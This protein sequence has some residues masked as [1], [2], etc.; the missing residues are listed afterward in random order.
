M[1]DLAMTAAGSTSNPPVSPNDDIN[2]FAGIAE[3]ELLYY[4]SNDVDSLWAV[5]GSFVPPP[6]RPP[7]L[8]EEGISTDGLTTCDLCTWA[9]RNDRHLS[10]SLD[11]TLEAPGE[12]GWV[13]TLIIVSLISAA[14]GAVVMVTLLHCRRIKSAGGRGGCCGVGVDEANPQE[15]VTSGAGGVA[16]GGGVSVIPD[17][18]PLELDKLPPY[19]D[20]TPT[21]GH[22]VWS[23]LGSRRGGGTAGVVTTPLSL[24]QHRCAINLPVENHYT[25]M[26]T[27]EALYAELDSQTASYASDLQLQLRGSSTYGDGVTTPGDEDEYHELDASRLHR[28]YSTSDNETLKRDSIRTRHSQRLK[29]PDYEMYENGPSTPI[30][31]H[32]QNHH[33]THP[34]P[35]HHHHHHH[36][37]VQSQR[38]NG[39]AGDV[40]PSYQNTGYTG[41]DNEPDGPFLSSAPSSAYYSDLSSNSTNHQS[42]LPALNTPINQDQGQ[43]RLAAINESTTPSDYI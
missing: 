15:P 9:L 41:S 26:Q 16:G 42:N 25:H 13:L 29:E 31:P 20:V 5:I 37:H 23:W 36:H 34:H 1:D 27:D 4:T 28:R 40:N 17:R 10:F 21:P 32:T 12:F 7:Y 38:N 33:H 11:G 18:P 3:E 8:P 22:N 39:S 19:H 14:I 2:W 30:P 6:P 35:H 24:P 43:Y